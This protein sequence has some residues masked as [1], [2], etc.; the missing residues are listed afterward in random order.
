M[1]KRKACFNLKFILDQSR[2]DKNANDLSVFLCKD[3]RI[4]P[5]VGYRRIVEEL[6][7]LGADDRFFNLL[8][9]FRDKF[10][11]LK[12]LPSYDHFKASRSSNNTSD[13]ST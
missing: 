2:K 8:D 13:M 10:M 11:T 9:H 3:N 1:K 5:F 12:N 7:E 4:S 6:E